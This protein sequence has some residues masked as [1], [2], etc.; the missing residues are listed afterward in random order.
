MQK[1]AFFLPVFLCLACAGNSENTFL[2]T[3]ST[4]IGETDTTALIVVADTTLV[5]ATDPLFVFSQYK[6]DQLLYGFTNGE[7]ETIIQPQFNQAGSFYKGL[8]PVVKGDEHGFCDI[9]GEFVCVFKDFEFALWPNE[10]AGGHEFQGAAEGF[11]VVTDE[12]EKMGY[13]NSRGEL[14]TEFIYDN[15]RE[16]SEGK[17]VVYLNEKA[18][19]IDTNGTEV[20][21]LHYQNAWS[22]SE[23]LAAVRINDKTGFID[24]AGK[25]IIPA[26]YEEA[27]TFSEGLCVVTKSVSYTNYYYIDQTGKTIIP[28]PY[29]DAADFYEGR[30]YVSKRGTCRII[31]QSGKELEKL[32]YDCF[33]G[34]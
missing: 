1:I 15:A 21:P 5:T 7:G 17:A 31:D 12:T 29:E 14:I 34:C 19:F 25:L 11:Y 16:F 8:A 24:H 22:F 13:V 23:G 6:N 2:P 4:A 33:G 10:L 32:D 18:G 9:T 28:G 30:A 26:I 3:D 20:V 27:Y